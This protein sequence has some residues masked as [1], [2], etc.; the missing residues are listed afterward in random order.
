MYS[1]NTLARMALFTKDEKQELFYALEAS[2]PPDEMS[3]AVKL[4]ALEQKYFDLVWFAR[5]RPE[6]ANIPGVK[7]NKDRITAAYPKEVAELQGATSWPHGFNSGML[8]CTRLLRAYALP[9]NHREAMEDSSDEEG[10]VMT[11]QS[12]IEQAEEDFPMLD[13]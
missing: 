4:K 2:L 5:S 3:V 12:E 8:A 9:H 11:K 10:F 6:N 1:E 7:A 13:T